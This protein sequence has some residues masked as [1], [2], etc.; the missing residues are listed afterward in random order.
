[1]NTAVKL[2][3]EVVITARG[4]TIPRLGFTEN[5]TISL[6]AGCPFTS[7]CPERNVVLLFS[8]HT[9]GGLAAKVIVV[10]VV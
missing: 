1:M 9:V 6:L 7:T 3:E 5:S 4:I 8:I 2:P 10:L